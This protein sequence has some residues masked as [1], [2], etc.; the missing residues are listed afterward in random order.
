MK[1][2]D[3]HSDFL[4]KA[5][6]SKSWDS[7]A[8]SPDKL[9]KG[10]V[11]LQ[12][13]AV[14][15]SSDHQAAKRALRQIELFHRLDVKRVLKKSDIPDDF[16]EEP[17]VLLAL[18]GLLPIDGYP[19]LLRVFHKLGVRMAS[20]V[21]SRINSFADGSLFDREPTGR[22]LTPHGKEALK[23]MEELSWILDISHLNDEGVKDA[24]EN[25][26]GTIVATH[27]CARALC[28]I[29]RNLPDEFIQE[30]AKRGGII[31]L[32][33]SPKFLTCEN[34]ANID[35]VLNHLEYLVKVAG[36]D[37]VGLGS[38][39][40][41]LP[42][43]PEGLESAEELPEF[44]EKLIERF[45]KDLAEKIAYKNWLKVFERALPKD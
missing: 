44:G 22:G 19:E 18:E 29:E 42:G 24:F 20:L 3:G 25:F 13:Y 32:N 35:D 21:W 33:Y 39:F 41:G 40:D 37:H 38:D 5:I 31:G 11:I 17:R 2:A 43:Y 6:D 45:G 12:V 7:L 34:S 26:S 15:V 8:S 1:F 28:D 10:N 9:K 16:S 36:E 27:S 23:I 30:I 4:S 14:Y